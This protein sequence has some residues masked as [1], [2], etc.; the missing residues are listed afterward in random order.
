MSQL[1]DVI[2]SLQE[3]IEE[4]E[5]RIDRIGGVSIG[6]GGGKAAVNQDAFPPD[7]WS[8]K[9]K[10]ADDLLDWDKI[11]GT[12][13]Q[14]WDAITDRTSWLWTEI[15]K[16]AGDIVTTIGSWANMIK[17]GLGVP[18]LTLFPSIGEN[19]VYNGE[20]E[21]DSDGD[22]IPDGWATNFETTGGGTTNEGLTSTIKE[23][24][25]NSYYM[26]CTTT[27]GDSIASAV[28]PVQPEKTYVFR[29]RAK[30][31]V[32]TSRGFYF[33][34]L[35]YANKVNIGRGDIISFGDIAKDVG[36]TT[37]FQEFSGKRTAPSGAYFARIACY[38]WLPNVN[39]TFYFDSIW[40]FKEISW[41]EM[42][43]DGLFQGATGLAK[44]G[45][46]L[47]TGLL[48]LPTHNM[49]LNSSFEYD[50]D[51]DGCPDH[52]KGYW[53][54]IQERSTDWAKEAKYSVKISSTASQYG[55]LR[56]THLPNRK[57]HFY[58]WRAWLKAPT[59]TSV[60]V[61]F[62]IA[63]A[64]STKANFAWTYDDFTITD[65]ETELE[66]VAYHSTA[67]YLQ[68]FVELRTYSASV[69]L[70]GA[71]MFKRIEWGEMI[72]KIID[73]T[74]HV[75]G[76]TVAQL[77]ETITDRDAWKAVDTADEFLIDILTW[78]PTQTD[79]VQLGIDPSKWNTTVAS[80]GSA[81]T[82]TYDGFPCIKL[83]VTTNPAG[84]ARLNTLRVIGSP[85]YAEANV[86]FT[87]KSMDWFL[88]GF[89]DLDGLNYV[90]FYWD[91]TTWKAACAV[92]GTYTVKTITGYDPTTEWRTLYIYWTSTSVTF[93]ID[94][95]KVA[96]ITEN[97]PT[98]SLLFWIYLAGNGTALS[99]YI[100]SH[101]YMKVQP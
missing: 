68:P 26:N 76:F 17:E 96:T 88:W 93:I 33:R 15:S 73:L 55:G 40:M 28:I 95:V 38:N 7:F 97:I 51:N 65:A 24:G 50:R 13:A 12:V 80:E 100:N 30:S 5:A 91:G 53:A 62:G 52:W 79:P 20:F 32:E 81:T 1:E 10:F 77:F 90:Y 6:G 39:A 72:G 86:K 48:G 59:G 31:D 41:L 47:I 92:G 78:H 44:F 42:I 8:D 25:T 70:D 45:V 98:A 43:Q 85:V 3:R 22:N 64:D 60:T 69:Y 29:C 63:F 61:R 4:L 89:S 19:M 18:F 101:T 67:A 94:K 58:V 75:I 46:D 84:I 36:L 23:E 35:W 54:N 2:T 14:F 9:T 74:K 66:C 83:S 57:G 87:A 34:V 82:E 11:A 27:Q 71:L 37:N 56:H 21:L 16:T 99:T 49:L